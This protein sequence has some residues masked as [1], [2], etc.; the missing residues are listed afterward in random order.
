MDKDEFLSLSTETMIFLSFSNDYLLM[1]F[2]L[3]FLHSY[4]SHVPFLF[5]LLFLFSFFGGGQSATVAKD[6]PKFTVADVDFKVQL[7]IS[8]SA[9]CWNDRHGPADP[10]SD[11]SGCI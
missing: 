8:L 3:C 2:S 9:K 1:P 10:A 4:V 6:S 5:W 11:C 7:L